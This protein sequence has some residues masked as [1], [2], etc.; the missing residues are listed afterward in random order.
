M[1]VSLPSHVIKIAAPE[2]T[3]SQFPLFK[4]ILFLGSDHHDN[5]ADS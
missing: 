2:L 3:A 4:N 5:H 1:G